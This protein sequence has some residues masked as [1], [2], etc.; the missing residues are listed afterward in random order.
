MDGDQRS[1]S[2]IWPQFKKKDTPHF[3]E[4]RCTLLD[5]GRYRWRIRS[6]CS[7]RYRCVTVAIISAIW[8]SRDENETHHQSTMASRAQRSTGNFRSKHTGQGS[9]NA[10]T[11]TSLHSQG[12]GVRVISPF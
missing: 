7:E 3:L 12:P 11:S 8:G 10:T 5:S 6:V 9:Q 4:F 2:V 1:I